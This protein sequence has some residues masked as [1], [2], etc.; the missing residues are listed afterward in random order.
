MITY[1]TIS[2]V[3]HRKSTNQTYMILLHMQPPLIP[4]TPPYLTSIFD[5][6]P[7][8]TTNRTPSHTLSSIRAD[9]ILTY[10]SYKNLGSIELELTSRQV[11]IKL[12]CLI[13]PNSIISYRTSLQNTSQT[14]QHTSP[15]IILAGPFN[16]DRTSSPTHLS[17]YWN[18]IPIPH[19]ICNQHIQPKRF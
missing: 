12:E 15:N 9:T 13:T 4:P 2:S 6:Y 3:F 10:S 1:S 14:S 18:H 5:S 11:L 19:P 8:T 17:Y 7:K 16:P